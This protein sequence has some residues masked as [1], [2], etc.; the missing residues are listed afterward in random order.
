[1]VRLA[2]RRVPYRATFH[3]HEL[4]KPLDWM[5]DAS[6]DGALLALVIHHV[7]DR[8]AALGE[9]RRVLRPGGFLVV[10]TH[11]PVS[12]WMRLGGSYFTA[13][14][15]EEGVEP[16]LAGPLLAAAPERHV[17]RVRPSRLR[18]R[19]AGRAPPDGRDG[20]TLPR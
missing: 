8:V 10:S 6:I 5:E 18:H 7:Y 16:G 2:R 4:G 11:H 19:A 15:L 9:I 20:G 3:V 17:R 14:K 12:D 1:M 13:E